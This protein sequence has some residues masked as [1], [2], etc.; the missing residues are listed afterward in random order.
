MLSQS[1]TKP[2]RERCAVL[3]SLCADVLF[4]YAGIASDLTACSVCMGLPKGECE[5]HSGVL[6]NN[7]CLQ[8][9]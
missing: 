4:V 9:E 7:Y 8:E 5:Q 3:A 1:I 6:D 2:T